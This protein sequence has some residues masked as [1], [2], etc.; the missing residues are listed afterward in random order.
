MLVCVLTCVIVCA[1]MSKT[2]V[3]QN[4]FLLSNLY[5]VE[6][7]FVIYDNFVW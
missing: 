4:V 3:G 1:C 6:D 5:S 2:K 7:G